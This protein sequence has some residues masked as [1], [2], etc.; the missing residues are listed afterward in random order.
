MG[1]FCAG[2][3]L[4]AGTPGCLR[5]MKGDPQPFRRQCR[6]VRRLVP[7]RH[8]SIHCNTGQRF[9]CFSRMLEADWNRVVSPGIVNNVAPVGGERDSDPQALRCPGKRAS[10]VTRRGGYQQD[11]FLSCRRKSLALYLR[12]GLVD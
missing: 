10:L 4:I 11:A 7:H 2:Q 1:K 12:P 8:N 6:N 9:R 5:W 3:I